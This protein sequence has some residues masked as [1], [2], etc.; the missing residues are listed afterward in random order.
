MA[1][2][3][4][5]NSEDYFSWL[6][7]H[8]NIAELLDF[9]QPE[10]QK[11]TEQTRTTISHWKSGLFHRILHACRKITM[12]CFLPVITFVT[13][14]SLLCELSLLPYLNCPAAPGPCWWSKSLFCVFFFLQS[15]FAGKC[16]SS[17]F[18]NK[19]LFTAE[20]S[21]PNNLALNLHLDLH[22]KPIRWSSWVNI[23]NAHTLSSHCLISV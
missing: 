7:G 13:D 12:T 17:A 20:V 1:L 16:S 11:V 2:T 4:F 21:F 19:K 10:C 3:V 6:D 8:N 23:Q 5:T 14:H 18:P 22:N 9:C 15:P